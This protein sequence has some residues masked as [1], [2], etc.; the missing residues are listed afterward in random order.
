M[1]SKYRNNAIVTSILKRFE[2]RTEEWEGR[3]KRCG[4]CCRLK[5]IADDCQ[6]VIVS[7]EYCPAL[8]L[9]TKTCMI[10]AMRLDQK[11]D[12]LRGTPCIPVSQAIMRGIHPPGCG[13][14]KLPGLEFKANWPGVT[15]SKIPLWY[16]LKWKFTVWRK[17]RRIRRLVKSWGEQK[18]SGATRS[19][20]G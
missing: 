18:S 9:K 7:E 16:R 2:D 11:F 12:I 5:F 19:T 20:T 1:N 17:R 4:E 10:Y 14:L 13:Y 6:S 3:C 8:D 15:W